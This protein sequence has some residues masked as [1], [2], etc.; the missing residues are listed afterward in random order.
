MEEYTEFPNR[1]IH[2]PLSGG[3]LKDNPPCRYMG[4]YRKKFLYRKKALGNSELQL[5]CG[6]QIELK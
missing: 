6:S 5:Q 2:W 3:T 1:Y 4:L